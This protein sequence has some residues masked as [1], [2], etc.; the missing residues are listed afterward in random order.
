LEIVMPTKL[1]VPSQ[2]PHAEH[3]RRADI[4]LAV[5]AAERCLGLELAADDGRPLAGAAIDDQWTLE[6]TLTELGKVQELEDD[7]D[8]EY[9]LSPD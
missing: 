6:R 7:D 8:E 1:K 5:H 4:A 2:I 3:R 9:F